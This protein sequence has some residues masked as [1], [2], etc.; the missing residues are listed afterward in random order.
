MLL[1]GF[2]PVLGP[3][4]KELP[5][6]DLLTDLLAFAASSTDKRLHIIRLPFILTYDHDALINHRPAGR[7]APGGT[8]SG[9]CGAIRWV[10]DVCRDYRYRNIFS[11]LNG[12]SGNS[13]YIQGIG[14]FASAMTGTSQVWWTNGIAET[15]N[16]RYNLKVD[17]FWVECES[18]VNHEGRCHA[19]NHEIEW[20]ASDFTGIEYVTDNQ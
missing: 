6:E 3:R 12:L 11:V 17:G 14:V 16:E 1:D 5:T 19:I 4:T 15:H 7:R 18:A 13:S 10:N 8:W 20:Y 2:H 9:R